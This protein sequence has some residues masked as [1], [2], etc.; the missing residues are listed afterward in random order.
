[1]NDNIA[2]QD[3]QWDLEIKPQNNAFDLHLHDVWKYRDLLG[4]L[5]RRDF[6][7]F[8][9]Q[10]ILGPIWFF[11]QPLVTT[12]MFTF[13]FGTLAKIPT[14]GLP[15]PLFYMAGITAWNY[16]ADCLTKTSTVFKDN[17]DIFGKVYFPRLIMPLSIVLS[18]LVRFGVQFLLFMMVM[19]F[20]GIKG[21]HFHLTWAISLF[22]LVVILMA[23]M[24]LGLGMIISAM[25]TKYRDLAFLI[26]FGIQLLMYATPIIYPL[27]AAPAKYK[28][29]IALNPMSELIETFRYGFLGKGSFSWGA[30]GYSTIMTIA[31]LMVGTVIFNKV[32]KSFVDTV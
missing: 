12:I 30:L 7:S 28:W 31:F 32:E 9:K 27:S 14:D 22:P 11:V 23:S 26:T 29:L 20:Y 2:L 21:A 18:N 25:T 1:M 4:L 10:T 8:Y 13:V 16:F 6:V 5:V 19:I 15:Q 17:A 3:Q 24:G